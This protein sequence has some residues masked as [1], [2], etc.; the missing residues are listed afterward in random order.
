MFFTTKKGL[1]ALQKKSDNEDKTSLIFDNY[2][3]DDT[4]SYSLEKSSEDED[5]MPTI[6]DSYIPDEKEKTTLTSEFSAPIFIDDYEDVS[7]QSAYIHNETDEITN[8]MVML[9]SSDTIKSNSNDISPD[10]R[11]ILN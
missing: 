10:Q 7:N 1:S 6:I 11:K 3:P 9:R 5:N 8:D 4:D 2:I